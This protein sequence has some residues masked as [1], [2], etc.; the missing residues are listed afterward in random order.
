MKKLLKIILTLT[1]VC[2]LATTFTFCKKNKDESQSSQE[3]VSESVSESL[4]QSQSEQVSSLVDLEFVEKH[5][6]LV[7]GASRQ[8]SIAN[9]EGGEAFTYESADSQV[10]T[11]D[12]SGL[13]TAN[14]VGTAIVRAH[15]SLG[16][17]AL[18]QVVVHDPNSYPTP[19]ISV[20]SKELSLN[21]GDN[22]VLNYTF[23][24]LGE[25]VE[26]TVTVESDN[27]NVVVIEDG[28]ISCV[29]AGKATVILK[30]DSSYG[31]TE[32][33]IFVSVGQ[34]SLEIYLS[35]T[36]KDIYVGQSIVL[37]VF[38]REGDSIS[39]IP[40][41]TYSVSDE[42]IASVV[43]GDLIPLSGG[44]T[45]V[46]AEFTYQEKSYEIYETI[47]VFAPHTCTV[48]YADG[49]VDSQFEAVY[50]D[51]VELK[52]KNESGN[53]ELGKGVK[54][55]YVNGEPFDGDYFVMPDGDVEITV[56]LNNETLDNF[57][58]DFTE[59]HLLNDLS[60]EVKY[61]EGVFTDSDGVSSDLGGYVKFTSQN[62]S[63]LVYNF[64]S[65]ISVNDY[66]TV[67]MKIWV[68]ESS[69]LLYFGHDRVE[70]FDSLNP[71][72]R[73]E[74]SIGEHKT[75]DVPVAALPTEKWTVLEMPLSVF[76][77]ESGELEGISICVSS[78]SYILIDYISVYTALD[79]TDVF[80]ADNQWIK[81][82]TAA[83]NGSA[84]QGN[85]IVEYYE[86]LQILTEEQ[87]A[88]D[89]HQN[90]VAVIRNIINS[91]FEGGLNTYFEN[92]PAVS[93]AVYTGDQAGTS[94]SHTQYATSTYNH[95]YMS[96]V[97]SAPHDATFTLGAVNYNSL[98]EVSFGLFA[99]M[100]NVSDSP[101]VKAYGTVTINGQS[102]EIDSS[103]AYYFKVV[104]S[105]GVLTLYEDETLSP[106]VIF[107]TTLSEEVL[108]GSVALEI[109]VN[110]ESW[111][112]VEITDSCKKIKAEDII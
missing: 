85:A 52:L 20:P 32:Q 69:V 68:P 40:G 31:T 90:N 27:T 4:S 83:E 1:F 51:N 29:G 78:N 111:S 23:T 10:V 106:E 104:I 59:G 61:I 14:A 25:A 8:L 16:R 79:K 53:P 66:S 98:G 105:G 57:T 13:I 3:S 102:Y 86:W 5:I 34:K 93:G 6:E 15:S 42:A 43:N 70:R 50:G 76:A 97:S 22:Y 65:P 60:S 112:Q 18:T 62:W 89:V 21:V 46:I 84:E 72:K 103:K 63:S 82:I 100:A 19:Y 2:S 48:K 56:R 74:A 91:Y 38:V 101:W 108:N 9:A 81:S 110:F 92:V 87:R 54:G 17:T 49:T 64:D 88:S 37:K 58:E 95:Y 35:V 33:R 39:E 44:D 24:Y 28:V 73:Y 41:V 26:G 47:H 45:E 55:W 30:G 77:S 96:Q 80:Y 67:K 107:T 7:V 99:V 12:G 75:G 36:G 94:F 109:S 71:S 11:V